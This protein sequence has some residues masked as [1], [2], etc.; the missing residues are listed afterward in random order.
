MVYKCNQ[1]IHDTLISVVL[2]HLIRFCY[3]AISNLSRFW[4]FCLGTLVLLLPNV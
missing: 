1:E 3:W 2:I 4:I